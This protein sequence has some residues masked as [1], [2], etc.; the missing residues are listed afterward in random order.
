MAKNT[1]DIALQFFFVLDPSLTHYKTPLCNT[2]TC[3]SLINKNSH[4]VC[5]HGPVYS[6][7]DYKTG[8][9]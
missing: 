3:T 7:P 8:Q 5:L 1:L 2:G 9:C 4:L 6:K